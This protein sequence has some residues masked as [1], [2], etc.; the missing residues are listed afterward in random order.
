MKQATKEL[1]LLGM[2]DASR[3][4][5]ARAVRIYNLHR[6]LL[7]QAPTRLIDG[8]R[9]T[10]RKALLRYLAG[11]GLGKTRAIYV[12]AS[13]STAT[14]LDLGFL[15]LAHAAGI[16]IL[17]FIP[18]AY[19]YF[20]ALYPRVGVKTALLDWGWRRS[21]AT[22]LRVADRLLFPS[23]GL[24]NYFPT[25]KPVTI[26]P[27]GG[28]V[29]LEP[30]TLNWD[31]P[32]VVYVGGANYRYGS[33]LLLDAMQQVVAR[34]P[35]ARCHFI[36]GDATYLD[37]HPARH[38]SWLTVERRA[39]HELPT[40]MR[41]ATV[42]VVPL[43]INEYNDLAVPVKLFDLREQGFELVGG[44]LLPDGSGKSAQLMYQ[45]AQGLRVTVYLRKPE[46]GTPAAFRYERQGELGLF[47][48]VDGASGYALVGPLP[49]AQLLALAEAIYR[50]GQA[51]N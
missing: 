17:I 40:V 49:R 31:R 51:A 23:R 36:S 39:F 10:R 20:P 43:R 2:F 11:G 37:Q 9:P 3:P 19:Q 5:R 48:W 13:T 41:A 27:P 1:V 14:E 38:A 45:D 42:A 21:I 50:Q 18:D 47:Y 24:A 34:C 29:G 26:L 6:A 44:R 25:D 7:A 8:D 16:P 35:T 12:E 22:Y 28:P 46:V 30:A 33:D 32:T 4:D 15:T